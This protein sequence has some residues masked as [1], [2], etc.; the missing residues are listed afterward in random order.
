MSFKDQIM[1]V[2]GGN[3]GIGRAIA[4]AFVEAEARVIIIGRSQAKGEATQQTIA[5]RGGFVEFFSVDLSDSAQVHQCIKTIGERY[6][7]LDVLVNNA[8]EGE[9][10]GGEVKLN[11]DEVQTD[12]DQ[13]W[14]RMAGSN[15][16]ST[17][18]M[19]TFAVGLMRE[20]GGA[21]VNIS[22]TASI[23]G[24]YGLYGTM[25]AGVEGLTRSL[26]VDFAPLNI[27][28]NAI[29]PGWIE[30]PNTFPN[31]DDPAQA[32]WF[33]TTSLF[34][35]MGQPEE[36]A[37]AVLFLASAQASF[38]TGATL[39]VDGGLSIIDPTAESWRRARA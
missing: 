26:A 32:E 33:N 9:S 19:S 16:R 28:V 27:R 5:E 1:I 18:L 23:H 24:N 34:E 38:I 20:Q 21:I 3:S 14:D 10:R 12:V 30:T 25:K 7:R 8:G 17:Y 11:P 22:S 2:T 35:R 39:V 15:L 13:R 36:I 6:G 4:M 29:S 31:P 37:T